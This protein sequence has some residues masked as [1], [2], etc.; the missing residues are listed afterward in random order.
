LVAAY[1]KTAQE[2]RSLV[3]AIT[4]DRTVAPIG[5]SGSG[6]ELSPDSPGNSPGVDP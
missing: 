2:G 1:N 4:T 3:E 5:E 6:T